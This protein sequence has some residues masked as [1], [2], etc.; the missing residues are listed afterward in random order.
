MTEEKLHHL[1]C[2]KSQIGEYVFLPGDPH[3]CKVIAEY[4]EN[5]Q[6]VANNREFVTYTGWLNN[7]RVSVTSTGIGGP[8]AAIAMEEL[9]QSKAHTFIRVGTCGGIN[10]NIPKGTLILPTA[11]IRK[12]GTADEYMP[13]E[14]PA[15]ADFTV[16]T[17]LKNAADELNCANATGVVECKDSYY[18]QHNPDSMPVANMLK[19]KWQMWQKAGALASEMESSTLFVVASVRCVRCGTVLMLMSNK[20][21]KKKYQRD[22]SV[23][24]GAPDISLAVKTAVRAMSLIIQNDKT[25]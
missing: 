15:V 10:P 25:E 7:T 8:S 18:G 14:F 13:K 9:V 23:N 16:L 2:F 1:G 12:D 3:R 11:A 5:P 17:A 21:R 22:D 20:E 24:E 6:L 4:L 19:D